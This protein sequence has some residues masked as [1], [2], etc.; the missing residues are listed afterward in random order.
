MNGLMEN[1]ILRINVAQLTDE[2]SGVNKELRDTREELKQYQSNIA[3]E[4]HNMK[5]E[6]ESRL[7]S[8]REQHR[9]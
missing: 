6:Y 3:T 8:L 5:Q 4:I 7:T 2:L 1:R 9:M